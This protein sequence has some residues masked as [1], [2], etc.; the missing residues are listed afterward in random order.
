MYVRNEQ[1]AGSD[2]DI[3]VEFKRGKKTLEDWIL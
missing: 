1:K 3:L 2:I